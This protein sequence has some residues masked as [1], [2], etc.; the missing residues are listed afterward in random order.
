M[1]KYKIYG[2]ITDKDNIILENTDI[3]IKDNNF[4]N[5]FTTKSDSNGIYSIEVEK[6][7]YPFIIGVRDYGTKYLEFWG[8]NIKINNDLNIDM[9]IDV[10]EIYGL[11]IFE[12]K[13][14][15]PSLMIYFRP[16]ELSKFLNNSEDISPYIDIDSVNIFINDMKMKNY[17]LNPVKEYIKYNDTRQFLTGYIIQVEKINLFKDIG[18]NII[19]IEI[20]SHDNNYGEAIIMY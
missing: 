14:A 3:I 13:G 19:K 18:E 8:N 15:Y 11:N 17:I 10:I 5:L 1:E 9:K 12:I 2:K 7:I 16:M 6:G 20:H 4:N